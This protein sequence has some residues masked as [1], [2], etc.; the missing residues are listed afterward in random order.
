VQLAQ[1][2][3]VKPETQ[4][5]RD[6]GIG[7]LLMRQIDIQADG[8]RHDVM[9]A[10]VG[11]LHD[12]GTA[13]GHH[14]DPGV[15]RSGAGVADQAPQLARNFVIMALGL[16]SFRD[17]NAKLQFG[18]AGIIRQGFTG[19]LHFT[20]RGGGFPYAGTA[21]HDDGV[22][23]P[24]LFEKKL[25][26]EIIQLQTQT[27]DIV[28]VE[29]IDVFVRLAITRTAQYGFDARGRIRIFLNRLRY[30]PG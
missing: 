30:M 13:A 7:K 16:N 18:I 23:D 11:R 17:R 5:R 10:P 4:I 26:F 9:G 20:L 25:G 6:V 21:E 14:H 24:M 8:F 19:K 22:A 27:P 1:R 2:K 29:E 15:G 3:I 28:T 12:A